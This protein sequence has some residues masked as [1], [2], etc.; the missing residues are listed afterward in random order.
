LASQTTQTTTLQQSIFKS[1]TDLGESKSLYQHT[2]QTPIHGTGQ[3]SC[4]SPAIC[5]MIS[6]VLMNILHKNSCGMTMKDVQK[7]KIEIKQIKERFVDDTS[8]FTN[9][10]EDNIR[11]VIEKLEKDGTWWSGLLSSSGGKLEMTKRFYYLL[12][13]KWDRNG[14][15][16]PETILE[17]SL[18]NNNYSISLNK[19]SDHPIFL[20]QKEVNV[21]H[22]R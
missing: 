16:V 20:E 10:E 5:L 4:A 18:E 3:G 6:S 15:P 1:R 12:S 8:I 21:T 17:Q 19:G 7:Y 14:N 2:E 11:S 13:W 9:D 22:K